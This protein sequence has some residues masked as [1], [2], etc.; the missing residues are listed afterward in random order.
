MSQT[1]QFRTVA[2]DLE[3]LHTEWWTDPPDPVVR[4]GSVILRRLLA[5]GVLQR[6]W[7][8]FGLSGEPTIIAPNLEAILGPDR[9]S[10][11]VAIAGGA[12]AGGV[13]SA[14][15][16]LNRGGIP[17]TNPNMPDNALEHPF[18]LSAFTESASVYIDGYVIKRREVVKYFAHFQG[19][20][21]LHLSSRIR[22]R[23]KELVQRIK[24]LEGRVNAFSK[25]GLYYELLSIG[26]SVGRAPDLQRLVETIRAA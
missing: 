4:R 15:L 21:H 22:K 10:I 25:D 14:A 8:H 11:R 20:A 12:H 24:R 23:D 9:A 16:V 7:K 17:H 1:A 13:F 3:H 2:E 19:G 26:Q 18:K 6:A 5:E